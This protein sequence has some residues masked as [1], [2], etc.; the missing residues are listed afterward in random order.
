[1]HTYG[2]Y[3]ERGRRQSEEYSVRETV[4][5]C[6]YVCVGGMVR[7]WLRTE[8]RLKKK[9][10]GGGPDERSRCRLYILIYM[11]IR[12]ECARILP[13]HYT[14]QISFRTCT[15]ANSRSLALTRTA[16]RR[17]FEEGSRFNFPVTEL[18]LNYS[19]PSPS[20]TRTYPDH[21]HSSEEKV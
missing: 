4:G 12:G 3:Q 2:S 15:I 16:S 7:R 10:N 9:P 19:Y 8:G 21:R 1:M 6:M 17:L 14:Y 20:T 18:R 5:G 11:Y 13:L